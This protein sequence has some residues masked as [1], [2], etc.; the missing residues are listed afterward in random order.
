MTPGMHV[1]Q[2][3]FPTTFWSIPTVH[4]FKYQRKKLF[5][6][7]TLGGFVKAPYSA[8]STL[9]R[10]TPS[11]DCAAHSSTFCSVDSESHLKGITIQES[12]VL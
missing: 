5:M 3:F 7:V 1:L 6:R 8:R 9:S 10:T 2:Y 11:L 4:L 12:K